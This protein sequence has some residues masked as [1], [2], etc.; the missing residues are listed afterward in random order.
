MTIGEAIKDARKR[1]GITQVELADRIGMKQPNVSE[2]EA[3]R[4]DPGADLIHRIANA[5]GF[6]PVPV[7]EGWALVD[8]SAFNS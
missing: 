1:A 4:K 5:T 6:A 2:Y 8:L 7:A 3:D